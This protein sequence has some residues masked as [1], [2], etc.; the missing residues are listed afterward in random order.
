MPAL[1]LFNLLKKE[2]HDVRFMCRPEDIS[3]TEKLEKI[4]PEIIKLVSAGW[5]RRLGWN[6]VVSLMT[7]VRSLFDAMQKIKSFD[8]HVT[9]TFGGYP[10]F[11]PALATRLLGSRVVMIEQNSVP[12]LANKL[13]YP[14]AEKIILN[15]SYTKR[16]FHRGMVIGNP[17]DP[18]IGTADRKKAIAFFKLNS[19]RKTVLVFGG[20][21]GARGLNRIMLSTLKHFSEYNVLWA[22]GRNHFQEISK[23]PETKVAKNLRLHAFIERMDLAWATADIV[24]SRAGA[25]TITEMKAVRIPGVL[26]PFPQAAENHQF[27]NAL[28][29]KENGVADVIEE[30]MLTSD[31]LFFAV[32]N[33]LVRRD[34]IKAQY[35]RFV[36][37][38]INREIVEVVV[39]AS[40]KGKK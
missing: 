19:K 15:Y 14:L 24:I 4:E 40:Q 5:K 36:T 21:Q 25:S 1:V 13:I 29:M 39:S 26:I 30:K 11:A 28:E 18:A 20:S 35:D 17:V 12:G 10:G 34:M 16:W 6:M 2:G 33:L 31:G 3:L 38:D 22:C 9:V 7:T 32:N 37:K 8:P 27:F 23:A